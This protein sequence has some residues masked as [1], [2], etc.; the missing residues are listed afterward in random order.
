MGAADGAAWREARRRAD[1]L[2][3]LGWR[4]VPFGA[5]GSSGGVGAPGDTASVWTPPDAPTGGV[6]RLAPA[7]ERATESG[8][9]RVT[10]L[11]DLRLED[12]VEVE[13]ILASTPVRVGFQ[14][15]GGD[16][17][18]AGL[19]SF[20][21]SDVG[22]QGDTATAR[23]EL[24]GAGVGDSVEVEV[25]EEGRPVA[26]RRMAVPAPGRRTTVSFRLPPAR[27]EGRLRYAA[28]I[29]APGDAFPADDEA[30]AYASV[31]A[32]EGGL[33]VVSLHPDWEPRALLAVLQ[34]VTGLE[35]AGYLR[36]GEN[37]FTPMGP[38]LQ[39]GP[40]VDSAAVRKA[41]RQAALLVIHG[42]D[43]RTDGW[44]RA[45][46]GT[47]SRTL[48]WPLDAAA[49]G[50][51]GVRAASPRGGEW[52]VSPDVPPSPL[53]ADLAG[54]DLRGLP[55]LGEVVPALPPE[56]GTALRVQLRGSGPFVPALLLLRD[57]GRRRAVVLASGFWRWAARDG[58]GLDAYRRLWSGVAGWLLAPDASNGAREARPER[59]VFGRGD[60]IR[61]RIPGA[62]T[63]SARLRVAAGADTLVDT[64][65]AAGA[66][67]SM[68][69]LAPGTYAYVVDGPGGSS[70]E[71]RFDVEARTLEMLPRRVSP[72]SMGVATAGEGRATAVLQGARPLRT[73]PWPYLLVLALLCLEWVGRRRVGLR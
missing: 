27:S 63:D 51:V 69:T 59:W 50:A 30:V 42:M 65:L 45:L 43:E 12:P 66:A 47:A 20:R 21:V 29:H 60:D 34:E 38:A 22:E 53:A 40:P 41:A 5:L 58:V 1:S 56:E 19:S 71:G 54:V 17:A 2:A 37:R 24:F 73:S 33:V 3:A 64:V 72:D 46:P 16:V 57:G 23:V 70:A 18:N 44:G 14:D 6:T 31:G 49:A 7:L 68:G 39:R 28:R 36:V 26:A 13:A 32:R 4:V 9:Q 52:Y 48:L 67:V 10:V 55:P 62:A 8:V 35:A 15:V 61:W 11:S 25:R